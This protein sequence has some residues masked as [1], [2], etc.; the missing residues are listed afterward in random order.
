MALTPDVTVVGVWDVP[1]RVFH[2]VNALCVL[3]LAGLGLV[4][5]NDN[6]LGVSSD[7][8]VLL[9]TAHVWVGYA[10]LGNLLWRFVWAFVGN[11]HARWRAILPGGR[12]YLAELR[13]HL[14]ALRTGRPGLHRGHNPLGRIAVAALLVVLLVQGGTG[15]VLAGTDIYY[16]P[17]GQIIADWVAAPGVEPGQVV[18]NRPELVDEA[19]YA[20][21]RDVRAPF[22]TIH[23]LGFY[24]LVALI[25]LHVLGVVLTELAQGG[26]LVSAMITGRKVLPRAEPA[27]QLAPVIDRPL[28]SANVVRIERSAD[29]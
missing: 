29:R 13:D 7:G 24:V 3:L 14:A 16:P 25:G 27:A 8:K 26:A 18:P 9:K 19:A 6:A 2:W 17:F 5:L 11:E 21:M 28:E 23:E 22:V 1:T 20:A 12:G 4:L 10:F 15:L